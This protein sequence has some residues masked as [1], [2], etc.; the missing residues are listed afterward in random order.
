MPGSVA[1]DDPAVDLGK[2]ASQGNL[3]RVRALLD[4]GVD[5]NTIYKGSHGST[6]KDKSQLLIL[7]RDRPNVC[8]ARGRRAWPCGGCQVAA[9][10]WSQRTPSHS[11]YDGIRRFITD[12]LYKKGAKLFRPSCWLLPP[13]EAIQA[14]SRSSRYCWSTVPTLM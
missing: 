6:Q 10:T 12:R 9:G 3:D 2:A 4:A 1:A 7:G 8:P 5:V 14:K 13:T 11:R